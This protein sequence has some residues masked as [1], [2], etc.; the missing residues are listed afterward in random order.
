MEGKEIMITPTRLNRL[1]DRHFKNAREA[2]DAKATQR[3]IDDQT[4][5]G[6]GMRRWAVQLR[7]ERSQNQKIISV[8]DKIDELIKGLK[9]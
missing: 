4:I 5:I 8:I 6:V 2:Q 3:V 1:A 7:D 9:R